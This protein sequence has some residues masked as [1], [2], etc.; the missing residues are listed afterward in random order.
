[1]EALRH[2]CFCMLY[3]PHSQPSL[4]SNVY[5]REICS[6]RGIPQARESAGNIRIY[7]MVDPSRRHMAREEW[8]HGRA[9]IETESLFPESESLLFLCLTV[10][11]GIATSFNVFS[12]MSEARQTLFWFEYKISITTYLFSVWS[13]ADCAVLPS[14]KLADNQLL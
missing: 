2:V 3:S 4:G 6:C 8:R 13:P 9:T 5:H 10:F 1:M 14:P 11:S 12:T 7:L